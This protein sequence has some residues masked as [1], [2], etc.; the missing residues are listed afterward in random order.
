ME[1]QQNNNNNEIDSENAE[2]A[3]LDALDWYNSFHYASQVV[4]G[5]IT[6]EML[7][8]C[9]EWEAIFLVEEVLN[10]IFI[11]NFCSAL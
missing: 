1:H 4:A 10:F 7:R 3:W 5:K 2:L 6:I 11:S 9:R 8:L